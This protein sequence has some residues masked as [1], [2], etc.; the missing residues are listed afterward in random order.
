[1]FNKIPGG[2]QISI[3]GLV[4][5]L[6]PVGKV[7]NKF[8]NQVEPRAIYKR[9]T[10]KADQ[11]WEVPEKPKNL[12]KRLNREAY[13]RKSSPN[14]YETDL[15]EYREREWD[16]RVNG[17]WFM[18][19]GEPTYITGQHY[20]MLAHWTIGGKRPEYRDTDREYHY[21]WEYCW[22]DPNSYGM[23]EV[24]QRRNGKSVRAGNCIYHRTSM[25]F[26]KKSGIQS[27]TDKDAER[28]FIQQVMQPWKRLDSIFR[29]V[30][31]KAQGSSPKKM[32]S[33][34]KTSSRTSKYDEI[35]IDG[36]EELESEIDFR[37]ATESA[38]DGDKLYVYI[39][40]ECGKIKN[41]SIY[42]RHDTV[43][44]CMTVGS[45]IIGKMIYTTT[46][47]DIGDSDMWDE[48]NFKRL[49]F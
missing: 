45:E 40:D 11:F 13:K 49:W 31:D 10:R 25:A 14:Y 6:P 2:S 4:C 34:N 38:Y 23:L 32:L 12:K 36:P 19:D 44:P 20:F 33:F 39:S 27:K 35:E 16:R 42:K 7:F 48:G 3:Q 21:F 24:T 43:K 41:A 37:A 5:N 8:T 26:N 29:P 47:E 15:Q 28:L 46:V 1:M 9:S 18:N 17:F 30:M 22:E